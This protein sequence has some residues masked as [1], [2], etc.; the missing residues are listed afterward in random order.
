[1]SK[2]SPAAATRAALTPLFCLLVVLL[3]ERG[4]ANPIVELPL[5]TVGAAPEGMTF[6]PDG[7]FWFC[8]AIAG[9]IGRIATNGVVTEYTLPAGLHCEP[10]SIVTGPDSNLW[11]TE[12]KAGRLGRITT[13]GTVT[14]FPLPAG[15]FPDGIALGADGRLWVTDFGGEIPAT[16]VTTNG[17]I[18]AAT[19]GGTNG[20]TGIS[21]YNSNF[22]GG[23]RPQNIISGPNG[24][25]FFTEQAVGRI[26]TITTSGVITETTTNQL[27]TNCQPFDLIT[28]PDGAVWFT[29]ANSNKLGRIVPN[30][31]TNLSDVTEYAL[32]TNSTGF[33]ADFPCG[34]IVGPDGNLWYTD[35]I[36]SCVTRVAF[37][38]TNLGLVTNVTVITNVSTN[39]TTNVIATQFFTPTTGSYPRRLA[40]GTDGNLWFGEF[41]GN[42][43]AYVNN[44][45]VFVTPVPL[46]IKPTTNSAVVLT[47]PTNFTAGFHLQTN[48]DLATTN[49]GLATNIPVIVTNVYVVTNPAASGNLFFRLLE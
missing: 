23:A 43:P 1:M 29:E 14:E 25:L 24:K 28:G 48:S 4:G 17:G 7:A 44:I 34:I 12:Y 15:I 31:T 37:T 40:K 2:F 45:G 22:T 26:G 35:P 27:A 11:F 32:P 33:T 18:F 42:Y 41:V 5:P 6:G 9:K 49:W 46:T 19:I 39:T 30:F 20:L 13:N 38:G 47:W 16:G 10:I 3:A 8:E 21:Y 36:A